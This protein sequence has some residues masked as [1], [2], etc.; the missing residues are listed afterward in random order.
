MKRYSI[1]LVF[2]TYRG[3]QNRMP[4]INTYNGGST[5]LVPRAV[6][7]AL[8]KKFLRAQEGF[9]DLFPGK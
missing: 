5:P 9:D 3:Q 1:S 2:K 8:P 6:R 4:E 7:N